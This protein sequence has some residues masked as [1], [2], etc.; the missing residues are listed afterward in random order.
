MDLQSLDRSASE[1]YVRGGMGMTEIRIQ[2]LKYAVVYLIGHA[3]GKYLVML[4]NV[5][6]H[7]KGKHICNECQ[8]GFLS[9]TRELNFI[10]C[11]YCGEPLDY[12]EE[13]ERSRSYKGE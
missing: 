13:D 5:G 4:Y 12:H 11:P 8:C 3:T 7:G 10:Y 2:I 1:L 9:S 6:K